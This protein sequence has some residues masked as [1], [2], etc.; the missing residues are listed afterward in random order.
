MLTGAM[1]SQVEQ[2]IEEA[3]ARRPQPFTPEK[4][5]QL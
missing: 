4:S 5:D 1:L 3:F 2:L